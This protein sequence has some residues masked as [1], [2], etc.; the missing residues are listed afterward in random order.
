MFHFALTSIHVHVPVMVTNFI[1]MPIKSSDGQFIQI[2]LHVITRLH[3]LQIYNIHVR[4]EL[5][6]LTSCSSHNI[7][8]SHWDTSSL[9]CTGSETCLGDCLPSLPI[10]MATGGCSAILLQ[11]GKTTSGCIWTCVCVCACMCGGSNM[12]L[13]VM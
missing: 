8:G 10:S 1:P 5:L 12:C 13:M 9:A 7:S 11:C 4:V 2:L 6:L 3:N